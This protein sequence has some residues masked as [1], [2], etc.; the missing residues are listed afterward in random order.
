MWDCRQCREAVEEKFDVCWNCGTARDGTVDPEFR[1]VCLRCGWTEKTPLE[2]A[3]SFR[4]PRQFGIRDL[5]VLMLVLSILLSI[6]KTFGLMW[7][8]GPVVPG[9]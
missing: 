1:R 6:L 2:L 3:I 8:V 7:P 9:W 4:V 5:L